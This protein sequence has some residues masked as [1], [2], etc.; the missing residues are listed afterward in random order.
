MAKTMIL[1]ET[2]LE[3]YYITNYG[4]YGCATS[5]I[6]LDLSLGDTCKVIWDGVEYPC[7]VE[8]MSSVSPGALGI[9]NLSFI[10]ASG[11]NEPFAIGFFADGGVTILSTTDTEAASHTVA[12][13]QGEEEST[14]EGVILK[15]RNG[16]DR[17]FEKAPAVRLKKTDGDWQIFSKGETTQAD[18]T[19]DFSGGDMV[20]TPDEDKLFSMLKILLPATLISENIADG[21]DVAGIIG[22]HKGGSGSGEGDTIIGYEVITK[23]GTFETG[24]GVESKSI[25]HNC[26]GMPDLVIVYLKRNDFAI[27]GDYNTYIYSTSKLNVG[28][29][30]ICSGLAYENG[31]SIYCT[32]TTFEV[33]NLVENSRYG[34]YAMKLVDKEIPVNGADHTLTFMSEDGTTVLCEKPV[35]NGDTSGDPVELGLI[36]K[37]E[38]ED[39][40]EFDYAFGGWSLTAGGEIDPDALKNITESKKLY[41]AFAG[42]LRLYT[43]KYYDGDTLLRSEKLLYGATPSYTPEKTGYIFA[44]WDK[45]LAPVTGDA[46]YY[47]QFIKDAVSNGTCGDNL[48]W[49]L[50]NSGVLTISGTGDMYDYT[51]TTMPWYDY[52]A[53]IAEVVIEDGVTSIGFF[54]FYDC[55]M[56]SIS[57][58]DGCILH[59]EQNTIY[60]TGVINYKGNQFTNCSNLKSLAIPEG[61]TIIP[62]SMC[63]GCS[64]LES[65]VIPSTMVHISESAFLGTKLSS[66]TIPAKVNYI[67]S[68]VFR[69]LSSLASAVFEDT[70]TWTCY[71]TTYSGS[72]SYLE[73]AATISSSDLANTSTA[74]TYLNNTYGWNVW[75]K[76]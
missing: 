40:A 38:K 8:D 23:S 70:T 11:N 3:F 69:L 48:K 32:T 6:I 21:I 19:L 4:M 42:L 66:V 71:K 12:I 68:S 67:G 54:A 76:T 17:T 39:T 5:N 25:T 55:K 74:A 47:A 14:V 10:G 36:K 24:S 16:I 1:T 29:M 9:G 57:I 63:N 20:V 64:S 49:V 37:P 44:G 72:S 28:D 15:D 73:K 7:T 50:S 22:S 53:D 31:S 43:I 34:W 56:T 60:T 58:P 75:K 18:I 13:Y 45:E 52:N 30:A 27:H 2:T 26:S 61:N 41:A 59:T 65:V 35:V 51:S 33:S 46:N 62:L